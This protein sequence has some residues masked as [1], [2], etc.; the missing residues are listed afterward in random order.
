[1][2][3]RSYG[4]KH[5]KQHAVLTGKESTWQSLRTL[6]SAFLSCVMTPSC[7]TIT[8]FISSILHRI[9][10]KQSTHVRVNL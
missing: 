10:N 3:I 1:M 6:C 8:D 5:T 2:C 7:C 9:S 4:A